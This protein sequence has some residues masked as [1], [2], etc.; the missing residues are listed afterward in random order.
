MAKY[1]RGRVAPARSHTSIPPAAIKA[2]TS[3]PS[4]RSEVEQV[5]GSVERLLE[6]PAAFRRIV[7]DG[8]RP[9][10]GEVKASL[11]TRNPSASAA[12]PTA[13]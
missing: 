6:E 4:G 5:Q 7:R 3:E 9:E 11:A 2:T 10:A 1:S 12:P 8:A 13:K